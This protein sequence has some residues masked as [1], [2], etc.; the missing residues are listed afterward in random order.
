MRRIFS[1]MV[2]DAS[3]EEAQAMG[4]VLEDGMLGGAVRPVARPGLP[5]SLKLA[6]HAGVAS[7]LLLVAA[8]LLAQLFARHSVAFAGV[9]AC[10]ILYAAALDRAVLGTHLGHLADPSA[11]IATRMT[12]CAG[13]T[14]TF[15]YRKTAQAALH[16]LEG[17]DS[18]PGV[19]REAAGEARIV[20][21]TSG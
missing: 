20:L 1:G 4:I 15:F 9:L 3:S 5:H 13:T 17:D 8:A 19:L 14:C 18:A 11:P 2:T 10:V 12:A 6:I 7:L 21:A 16:R